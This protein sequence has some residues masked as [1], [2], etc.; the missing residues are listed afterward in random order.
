[1]KK[2]KKEAGAI[3]VEATISLSMFIFTLYTVLSLSNIAYMQMR[4]SNALNNAAKEISEYTYLYYLFNLDE[5]DATL[6]EGSSE[7]KEDAKKS[8]DAAGEAK[9]A[10]E[11][12]GSMVGTFSN[13]VSSGDLNGLVGMIDEIDKQSNSEDENSIAG[14]F[15]SAKGTAGEVIDKIS[16]DPTAFIVGLGRLAVSEVKDE[17][18]VYLGSALAKSLMEKN[19]KTYEDDDPDAFLKRHQIDGMDSLDFTGTS[20]LSAGT[21]DLIQF[22]CTYDIHVIKLL[23]ID[24]TFRFTSVAK[25]TAW[26]RG[27]SIIEENKKKEK[28]KKSSSA[29]SISFQ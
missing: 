8:I 23:N 29:P 5:T 4:M 16:G 6:S 21:S 13:S 28:E 9:A 24:F 22:A 25:T 3:V 26:G 20:F 15:S 18:K 10:I 19:L 11:G 2:L 12:L 27:Y 1:M 14:H 17:V 7:T